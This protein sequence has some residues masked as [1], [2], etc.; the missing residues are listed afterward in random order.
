MYKKR[1]AE[2]IATLSSADKWIDSDDLDSELN[3][4]PDKPKRGSFEISVTRDD[5][6]VKQVWSGLKLGPPRRLKF[7]E[8]S[9][10]LKAVQK[11]LNEK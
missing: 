11:A 8:A 2:Q 5:G 9:D 3:P 1:A 10:L 4:G 7:P 6:K